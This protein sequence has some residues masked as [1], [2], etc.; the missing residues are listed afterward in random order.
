MRT[1]VRFS[2]RSRVGDNLLE[3]VGVFLS[4]VF[5][6]ATKFIVHDKIFVLGG[7]SCKLKSNLLQEFEKIH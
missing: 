1:L 7:A 6:N 3:R 5:G 2:R 4:R